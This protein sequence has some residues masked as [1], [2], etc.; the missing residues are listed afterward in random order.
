[1]TTDKTLAKADIAI[2]VLLKHSDLDSQI[3]FKEL[4]DEIV[5]R[6]K[7]DT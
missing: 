3:S 5:T 6:W 4:M 1:M 7:S 2:E